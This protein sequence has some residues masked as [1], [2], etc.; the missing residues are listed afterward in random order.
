[1]LAL[2]TSA[3]L[4]RLDWIALS[5]SGTHS[6]EHSASSLHDR[7]LFFGSDGTVFFSDLVVFSSPILPSVLAYHPPKSIEMAFL[8]NSRRNTDESSRLVSTDCTPDC[9]SSGYTSYAN[10]KHKVIAVSSYAG[11]QM[12]WSAFHNQ[13]GKETKSILG[14]CTNDQLR[15]L[16]AI[17][18]CDI[19]RSEMK[20]Y[21]TKADRDSGRAGMTH[22]WKR[23]P[24]VVGVTDDEVQQLELDGLRTESGRISGQDIRDEARRRPI[25]L[26]IELC[27]TGKTYMSSP[28]S[29]IPGGINPM[30]YTGCF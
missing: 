2:L 13:T 6:D 7:P 3:L 29:V 11:S 15:Y 26:D 12:L 10:R 17:Q 21:L 28:D 23:R 27:G 18:N 1:M 16:H 14:D 20:T 25:D 22:G 4:R 9:S 30:V 24:R 5:P 8:P 19:S